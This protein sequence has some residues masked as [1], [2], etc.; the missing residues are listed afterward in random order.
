MTSDRE[1]ERLRREHRRLGDALTWIEVAHPG[2]LR[3][4]AQ[5]L[6]AAAEGRVR[7]D[8]DDTAVEPTESIDPTTDGA[9]VVAY[10]LAM[11]ERDALRGE[12]DAWRSAL[13]ACSLDALPN[14]PQAACDL[15]A[16]YIVGLHADVA[17][18]TRERDEACGA[19]E[20]K[21]PREVCDAVSAL[22]GAM[23]DGPRRCACDDRS[24][25]NG[26]A[27]HSAACAW[28]LAGIREHYAER[29][30][31]RTVRSWASATIQRSEETDDA[32]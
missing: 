13:Q 23:S 19:P 22:R 8:D 11:R 10:K 5:A 27:E 7:H 2:G 17:R 25:L 24:G 14:A 30:L 15:V 16:A 12:R 26:D 3:L 1:I 18:L 31:I 21:V 29:A 28:V 9:A 6:T 32:E 4:V 20:T